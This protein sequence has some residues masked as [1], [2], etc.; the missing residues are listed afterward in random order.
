MDLTSMKRNKIEKK[1]T[2]LSDAPVEV[3]ADDYPYGLSFNLEKE[4]LDKLGLD[5]D[6]FSIDSK[7]EMVCKVEVT[8]LH[9]NANRHN[10][11][12]SVTLQIT[13]MAM[14]V[15][16]NENKTKLKEVMAVIKGGLE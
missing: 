16:P 1:A 14:L 2:G 6:D 10:T 11:S 13:D 7:G 9:E 8:S 3:D 15:H 12:A 4:S 5:V